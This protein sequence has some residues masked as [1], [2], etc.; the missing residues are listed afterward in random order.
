LSTN[1]SVRSH[2]EASFAPVSSAISPRRR[3][4]PELQRGLLGLEGLKGGL[5]GVQGSVDQLAGVDAPGVDLAAETH[6]FP[7]LKEVL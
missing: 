6:R 4:H 7:P 3:E 2:P 5:D 1:R